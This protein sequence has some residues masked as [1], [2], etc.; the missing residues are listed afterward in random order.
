MPREVVIDATAPTG[1][2][3]VRHGQRRPYVQLPARGFGGEPRAAVGRS[4][5]AD[6]ARE[7]PPRFRDQSGDQRIGNRHRLPCHTHRAKRRASRL[8]TIPI[9]VSSSGRWTAP[10]RSYR[11]RFRWRTTS[12]PASMTCAW[13]PDWT[14]RRRFVDWCHRQGARTVVL[15]LGR[16][17][18]VVSDGDCRMPIS[19]FPVDAVDATGAGDCF[20]GSFLATPGGWRRT[21]CSAARWASAAAALTT[22][23]Y[24]AVAPLPT[25]A[26]VARFMET[27]PSHVSSLSG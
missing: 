7:I 27:A 8:P 13:S 9:C 26:Q 2:Y 14:I 16:E 24:G 4:D 22:T 17:G 11:Q 5:A 3:F 18:S 21:S 1:I 25:A 6:R 10:A 12:C 15:K 19:A 23:G 20:D